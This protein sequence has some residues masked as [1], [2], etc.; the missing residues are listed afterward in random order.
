VTVRPEAGS[1][2]TKELRKLEIDVNKGTLVDL[3]SE[4]NQ[5][6]EEQNILLAEGNALSRATNMLLLG[7]EWGL[8]PATSVL[9]A[10][11]L[12]RHLEQLEKWARADAA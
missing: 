10:Q 8:E 1:K 3:V 6:I 9:D 7:K 12:R 2:H 4:Q 5:K 11:K